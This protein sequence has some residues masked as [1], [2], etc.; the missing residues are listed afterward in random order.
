MWLSSRMY[1]PDLSPNPIRCGFIQIHSGI[2]GILA[3]SWNQAIFSAPEPRETRV[4]GW[5]SKT[6]RRYSSAK[7]GSWSCAQGLVCFFSRD[8]RCDSLQPQWLRV[9]MSGSG[10]GAS[11][12]AEPENHN[13]TATLEP[14]KLGACCWIAK[15]GYFWALTGWQFQ[16]LPELQKE[17]VRQHD[18]VLKKKEREW[19]FYS[20]K[21]ALASGENGKQVNL[22][23]HDFQQ[24][25]DYRYVH[26]QWCLPFSGRTKRQDT[27]KSWK[28]LRRCRRARGDLLWT[29]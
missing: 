12:C 5:N 17:R 18:L 15:L 19:I 4:P 6:W 29:Y 1:E 22:N 24:D 14:W 11:F 16:I 27:A 7:A 21:G 13:R 9:L 28:C 8:A 25:P 2:S 23:L 3:F 10:S 26:P 20:M